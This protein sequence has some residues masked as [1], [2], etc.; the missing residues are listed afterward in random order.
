MEVGL[1]PSH[2]G[3]LTHRPLDGCRVGLSPH[4]AMKQH[5]V[6]LDGDVDVGNIEP[7]PEG[8]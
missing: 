4:L 1:D 6:A 3:H 5:H 8:A 2:T 7:L